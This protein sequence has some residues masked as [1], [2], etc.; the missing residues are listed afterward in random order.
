MLEFEKNA[1]GSLIKEVSEATF[2]Q[3]VIEA[4]KENPVIVDFWAPW[5]GPCKTLGPQLEEAV[6]AANGAVTMAKV[7]VDEN[8]M[9]AGQMQVQS[10]PTVFA[11]SNGQPVDGFQGAV[12]ASEI[13]AFVE[14]VVTANGGEVENGLDTAVASAEQML[15]EGDF[16]AA[17]ETFSAILEEDT[18]NLKSYIGLIKCHI[19]VDDLDQAEAILNGA[20]LEIS[21]SPEIESVHAQIELARQA[22]DAGPINDLAHLVEKK[23]DD[24][25][26]RFKLAQA[27]HG[28]GQVEEAV[29]QLL[30]LFKRDREWNDGAAKA[31]LFIIFEALEPNNAIVLNGRRKLSSLIFA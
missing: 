2:M 20:P 9:I 3:D 10:I 31:Q 14:R 11:F 29:D 8:Q 7:N 1:D 18:N 5:C 22:L 17:I 24:H 30:E 28:A 4:S 21:Q 26:S 15:N 16:E 12:S 13:K 23:P 25:G 19:A 6:K 27:L